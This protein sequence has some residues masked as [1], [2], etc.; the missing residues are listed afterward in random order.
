MGVSRLDAMVIQSR[1]DSDLLVDTAQYE[2]GLWA[3]WLYLLRDGDIDHPIISTTPVFNTAKEAKDAIQQ[4]VDTI[5]VM[6]DDIFKEENVVKGE[7]P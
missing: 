2:T 1:S 7:K 4:M 5:R 3:G 6:G